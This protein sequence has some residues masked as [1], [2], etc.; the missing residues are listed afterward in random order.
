MVTALIVKKVDQMTY[1]EDGT[2]YKF[3]N[4]GNVT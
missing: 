1:D 3:T 4:W 2:K